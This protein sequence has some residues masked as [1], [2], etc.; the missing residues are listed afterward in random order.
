MLV[1][2]LRNTLQLFDIV[3]KFPSI[4]SFLSMVLGVLGLIMESLKFQ[5]NLGNFIDFWNFNILCIILFA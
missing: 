5:G 3:D 1:L 4:I 2:V